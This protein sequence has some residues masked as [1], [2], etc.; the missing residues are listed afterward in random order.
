M[1]AFLLA[2]G[3]KGKRVA[4]PHSRI[5]I[6]QPSG[7]GMRGQASD[8][9]IQA[10]EVLRVKSS[11]NSILAQHSGQPLEKVERDVERDFYMSA[12]EAKTYG[13]VDTVIEEQVKEPVAATVA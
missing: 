8:L 10:K 12:E 13:I 9:A 2:A 7:G 5:M 1:G 4:L 3:T 11:L 6:H